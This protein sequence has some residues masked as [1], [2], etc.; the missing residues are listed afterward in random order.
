MMHS[1]WT[2]ATGMQ[3]QQMRIDAIA[4][5]LANVNTTSYKKS[6]VDFQD[7][8]YQAVQA[9][10]VETAGMQVGLGVRPSAISKYHAQGNLQVTNN[11]LDVAIDGF[12]FFQVTTT[13]SRVVGNTAYTR[14]GS[15]K[16]NNFGQL[17]TSSGLVVQPEI[18]LGSATDVRIREDGAVF[19]RI[20]G[21]GPVT[22]LG[23][24]QLVSFPNPAGMMSIGNNLYM[25]TD[26][27]GQRTGPAAGGSVG[28]GRVVQGALEA[29]NV[30][31]VT[32]MVMMI[33]TQKAYDTSSKAINVSD[34]MMESTNGLIR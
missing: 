7:L 26:A 10:G 34:K 16:I 24:L 28:M 11:P 8:L 9:P 1:I 20:A 27:A 32:E 25:A 4:N 21:T 5:N 6:Q 29:S 18:N 17:V 23:A 3:A 13:D 2:A 22:E 19:G 30:E 14:D 33:A 31:L 15:F 12:G